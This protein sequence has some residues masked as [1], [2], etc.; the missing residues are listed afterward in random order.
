MVEHRLRME[1]NVAHKSCSIGFKPLLYSHK[2][3]RVSKVNHV[4]HMQNYQAT[5]NQVE[6]VALDQLLHLSHRW[7]RKHTTT[8]PCRFKHQQ[9]SVHIPP[10][11]RLLSWPL[12]PRRLTSQRVFECHLLWCT[13]CPSIC[14][15]QPIVYWQLQ[16]NVLPFILQPWHRQ[17]AWS[18][19]RYPVYRLHRAGF[20]HRHPVSEPGRWHRP[21]YHSWRTWMLA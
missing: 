7:P 20:G 9:Y 21:A 1:T 4:A 16:A 15:W 12:P 6:H 11:F 14:F 17:P 2:L 8:T 19:P 3:S 5:T 18:W 13:I 10:V